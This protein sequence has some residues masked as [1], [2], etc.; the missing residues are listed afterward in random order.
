MSIADQALISIST[1]V[2]RRPW[3]PR[4]RAGARQTGSAYVSTRR[5]GA[6]S[7]SD[8]LRSHDKTLPAANRAGL[9]T[10]PMTLR[11][12]LVIRRCSTNVCQSRTIIRGGTFF[13]HCPAHSVPVGR[14]GHTT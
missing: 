12:G 4:S 9:A 1:A 14:C 10:V 6:S 13:R 8:P 5:N 2:I 3:D 11:D 7:R